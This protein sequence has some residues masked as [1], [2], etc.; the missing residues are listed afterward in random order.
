MWAGQEGVNGQEMN[1]FLL[2]WVA[3]AIALGTGAIW[4][5]RAYAVNLPENRGGF[6]AAMVAATSI[7][8]IAFVEGAGWVGGI[9]AGI[10][11][12]IGCFL[13][14][15]VAVSEQKGG[16]GQFQLGQP[17]PEFTAPDENGEPF[18]IASL[19]GNPLLLKFFRGHW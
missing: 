14:L 2:G 3:F 5:R 8:I 6:V 18:E 9:P 19:I 10:A 4:F 15:T 1:G 7:G 13:L 17:V 11:I 16:T 12:L